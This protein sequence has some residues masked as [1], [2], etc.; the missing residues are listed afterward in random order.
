[1]N[2][3]PIKPNPKEVVAQGYNQIAAEY[4]KWSGQ[5]RQ[6]ERER[7]TSLV[8]AKLPS[9]AKVLDLG[10]GTGFLTA[11]VLAQR[12][13]VTGADI[14]ERHIALAQENV[15][16][17]TFIHA[18]MTKLV[19]PADSFDGIVAFYSLIHLPREEQADMLPRIAEWLCPGGLFVA[20]FG[21]R[22]FD[23]EI[24][25]DWLGTTMYWSSYDS[26]TNK[27]LVEEAGLQ[28]IRAQEETAEE[29]DRPLTFLWIV[30]QKPE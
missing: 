27:R 1:M 9:G 18:D 25:D 12:F 7:Y 17:A 24:D 21:I 5:V 23:G 14:S 26:G 20:T 2:E 30:A 6:A 13:Q 4:L 10:C 29:F 19:F 16:E 8:L 22:S 11:K 28:I 15:P 3:V